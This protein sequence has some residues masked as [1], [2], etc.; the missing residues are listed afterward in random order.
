MIRRISSGGPYEDIIGYSRAVVAGPLVFV[1]G[2]TSLAEG[3][4][5]QAIEAFG[6]ALAALDEAGAAVGD[7][8]RTRMFLTDIAFAHDVGRAHQ[9]LFGAVRPAA[10]MVAVSAI[11]DP[12]MLVEVELVAYREPPP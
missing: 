12:R 7:V 4:F 2:C 9:E 5:A 1:S 11:V 10:T 8:V 3:A 6:V